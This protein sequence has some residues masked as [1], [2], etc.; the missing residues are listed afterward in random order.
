M[1]KK[2]IEVEDLQLGMWVVELDRP[3]LGTPFDFQGFPVTSPE[4]L[5]SVKGYCKYVYVDPERE[6]AVA[7]PRRTAAAPRDALVSINAMPVEP[8]AVAARGVYEECE[9]AVYSVIEDL[10]VE[11]KLDVGRLTVAAAAMTATIQRH[12]DAMI[13]LHR[14]HQKSDYE[15]HR[16]MDS[17]I[18]MIT[19]GHALQV[20]QGRLEVLGLAGMLLD[21]GKI[22]IP[23][24][25]LHKTGM[26]TPDEYQLMKSHVMH[27]VEMVRGTEGR[28][29]SAV[30]EIIL[31]HHERQDG[32]G[33]PQG[34]K[35]R[36]ISTDAAIAAI[37]DNFSALTSERCFAEPM[38]PSSALNQLH[39]MRGQSFQEGLVEQ[40]IQCIGIYPVGSA[41]ELNTGEIGIVVTQNPERRL[42]PSVMLVLDRNRKR[43]PQ[44][45]LILDL[46]KAPKTKS[47]DP[48]RIRDALAI[49][50]LPIDPAE[51]FP[52]WLRQDPGG[53]SN[54]GHQ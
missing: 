3:W 17:S 31:Q 32:N 42:Q 38:S 9:K 22:K 23:D 34:L 2:R 8:E 21:V 41:V 24:E 25:V 39:N 11:G 10:R 43:L 7:S 6:E 49:Q 4:Q 13:L 30:E 53:A 28:L 15:L 5:Q 20:D 44:P 29:P 47:G 52:A 19:F 40:F 18:L 33:Y 12:P 36:D 48:Y 35:G 1:N 14:L 46:A 16:A 50:K 51:C 27:S 45:Q 26:L 54:A 37:V